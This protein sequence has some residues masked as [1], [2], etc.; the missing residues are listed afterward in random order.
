MI[1]HFTR[2]AFLL[3]FL[4]FSAVFF[5]DY[6]FQKNQDRHLLVPL[7]ES[8]ESIR[9]L[10][11]T[12]DCP[13]GAE[14]GKINILS[15]KSLFFPASLKLRLE[16]KE[17][18]QVSNQDEKFFAY[19][20]TDDPKVILRYGPFINDSFDERFWYTSI[21]YSLLASAIFAGLFPLFREM[22]RLKQSA[23]LFTKS[24][25]LSALPTGKSAFFKPVN[26]AFA[27][28]ITKIARL[29]AL[30]KELSDTLSHE[31]RTP[32]SRIRFAKQALTSNNI[33]QF[34]GDMELDVAEM[35]SLVE[36]YLSFSRLEHEEPSLETEC[37]SIIPTIEK[38]VELFDKFSKKNVR[39][40]CE[41]NSSFT[42]EVNETK[43][44]RAIKNLIDNACKFA[45][46]QVV[47]SL[48]IDHHKQE[49]VILVEDDGPGIKELNIDDLFLP[50]ARIKGE[51]KPGFGLGLAI[52]RKIVLWHGG[53]ISVMSNKTLSGACFCIILPLKDQN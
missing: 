40:I 14:F 50:Y 44:S 7:N 46:S 27:T 19:A 26:I 37:I 49:F 53:E 48:K 3:V 28:M 15:R 34:K 22:A 25:E 21:F 38:H 13:I 6:F 8:I 33:E 4:L 1:S 42:L 47:V 45:K 30:Q 36:E 11:S 35:E 43:F 23:E 52:T 12:Q 5:A 16:N 32:L 9:A 39:L 17:I 2:Y 20:I 29:L 51:L 31:I 18:I 41:E 10:C 24:G